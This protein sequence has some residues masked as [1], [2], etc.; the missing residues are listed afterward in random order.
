[1]TVRQIYYRLVALHGYENKMTN[2]QYLVKS[3]TWARRNKQLK[4]SSIEDRTRRFIGSDDEFEEV[5]D[6]YDRLLKY[7]RNWEHQLSYPRWYEQE[8]YVEIWIEKQALEGV[9]SR[10][11]SNLGVTLAVCRGYPSLTYLHQAFQRITQ[12]CYKDREI[13]RNPIILYFGDH[14]PSG[15]DIQ[16]S[17]KDQMA[18][19]GWD[20][21]LLTVKR[22]A[23]TEEQIDQYNI[24]SAPAKT[25]D[26]RT[27]EGDIAVEL[28]A[29]DPNTLDD[30]TKEAI[31]EYFD[32]DV[33]QSESVENQVNA[34]R[35]LRDMID[36]NVSI[37]GD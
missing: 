35:I 21:N 24:P 14:D 29:L 28:D 20:S 15:I 13:I 30:L 6:V 7:I 8:N 3:L 23:I 33:Y 4:Y 11:I 25:S 9:F 10:A 5:N 37:K 26:P 17:V 12:F 31:A 22:I 34:R 36:E 27:R 18:N 2:Y 1:M 16:R 32:E 19:W